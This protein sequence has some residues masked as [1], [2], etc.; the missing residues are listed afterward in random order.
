M[1]C[2]LYW[3]QGHLYLLGLAKVTYS[4]TLPKCLYTQLK[5]VLKCALWQFI[6]VKG[7]N[8]YLLKWF[9]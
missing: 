9:K 8:S 7:D 3:D 6:K 4:S 1:A 2:I 5:M